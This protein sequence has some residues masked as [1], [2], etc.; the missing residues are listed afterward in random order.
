MNT[1]EKMSHYFPTQRK[2]L[3]DFNVYRDLEGG[4]L[5]CQP[6]KNNSHDIATKSV[7]EG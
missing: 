1:K 4:C 3:Q 2:Q 5:N 6:H 7:G